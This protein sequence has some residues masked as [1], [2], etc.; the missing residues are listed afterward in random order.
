MAWCILVFMN[1]KRY[2]VLGQTLI[3]V[4]KYLLTT[5]AIGAI[6]KGDLPLE[7]SAAAITASVVLIIAGLFVIPKES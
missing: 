7:A 5:V 3:D 4:G 6:I 1:V 2:E